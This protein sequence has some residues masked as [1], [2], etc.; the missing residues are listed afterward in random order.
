MIEINFTEQLLTSQMFDGCDVIPSWWLTEHRGKK[1]W[2]KKSFVTVV[3]QQSGH[4]HSSFCKVF[5]KSLSVQ[6]GWAIFRAE[7]ISYIV[8]SDYFVIWLYS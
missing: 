6:T 3:W 4:S 5:G 1:K 8:P 7:N 2:E